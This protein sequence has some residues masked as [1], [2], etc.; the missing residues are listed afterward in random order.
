MPRAALV[1]PPSPH[2]KSEVS[3]ICGMARATLSESGNRLGRI[4]GKLRPGPRQ[5]RGRVPQT[6]RRF[7]C[8]YP[9]AGR[10]SS[11]QRPARPGVEDGN[12]T[13]EFSRLC[14]RGGRPGG[15]E[16][17]G[18]P[19]D[20]DSEPRPVQYTIYSLNDRYR[21]V[22]GGRMVVFM[23]KDDMAER[24]I[25]PDSVIELESL[26]DVA[27]RRTAGGFK[28][29]PYNI[30]RGSIA[31]YYPET[32]GLM[33]LSHH[34]KKSK[35]PSAKS[36]PGCREDD[37]RLG[38]MPAA[39]EGVDGDTSRPASRFLRWPR[40]QEDPRCPVGLWM[41]AVRSPSSIFIQ[42]RPRWRRRS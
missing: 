8:P 40:V 24:Q 15:L 18:A 14:G 13:R 9:R 33:P 20:D 5:D 38:P 2:L 26:V 7:Q 29:K 27:V 22:F 42:G 19:F 39:P 31:A 36:I 41:A 1:T 21:G 25:M 11:D 34:D 16:P 3:I 10:L 28:V 30:P 6:I 17:G 12:R 23:N 4:R 37:G 35:T 32:N